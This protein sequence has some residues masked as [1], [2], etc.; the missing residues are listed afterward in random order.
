MYDELA[1]SNAAD[2]NNLVKKNEYKLAKIAEIAMKILDH[3]H[4]HDNK[5]ITTQVFN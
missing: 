2:N 4:D 1:K 3:D 5:Y